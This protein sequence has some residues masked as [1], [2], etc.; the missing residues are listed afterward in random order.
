MQTGTSICQ[1]QSGSIQQPCQGLNFRQSH[2]R[3]SF[4]GWTAQQKTRAGQ[5]WYN[6]NTLERYCSRCLFLMHSIGRSN[7]RRQH[8][9]YRVACRSLIQQTTESR[10]S[11][12]YSPRSRR[13][14]K[15]PGGKWQN[16]GTL[17]VSLES[18]TIFSKRSCTIP[19]Y[20]FYSFSYGNRLT[21]REEMTYFNCW[22]HRSAQAAECAL[23]S[24]AFHSIES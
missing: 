1:L 3:S 13:S 6:T 8:T 5:I 14:C 9:L 15:I 4:R 24:T 12:L 2:L 21:L 23:F 11:S 7:S 19:C 17:P 10:F 16:C 22:R 20:Q 18:D